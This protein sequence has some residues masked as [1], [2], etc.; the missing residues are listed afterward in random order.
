MIDILSDAVLTIITDVGE[1]HP[2]L[3]VRLQEETGHDDMAGKV[4]AAVAAGLRT[5]AR[6]ALGILWFRAIN[7]VCVSF[8]LAMGFGSVAGAK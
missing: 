8:S 5:G 2:A 1:Q 4:V 3:A 7:D 6:E